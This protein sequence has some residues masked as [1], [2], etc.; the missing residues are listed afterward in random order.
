MR[1]STPRTPNS[2]GRVTH[3]KATRHLP[4]CTML[5]PVHMNVMLILST[6]LLFHGATLTA[7]VTWIGIADNVTLVRVVRPALDICLP[8]Q[9]VSLSATVPTRGYMSAFFNRYTERGIPRY[10][11]DL[12][13]ME[14]VAW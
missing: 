7:M 11:T 10:L 4:P 6:A 9:V 8:F 2:D 12:A 5:M 3:D 1:S 14:R 13:D